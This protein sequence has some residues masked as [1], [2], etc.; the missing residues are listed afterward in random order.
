MFTSLV[1]GTVSEIS[2]GKFPNGAVTGTFVHLFNYLK[3]EAEQQVAELRAKG[4]NMT[5]VNDGT[6]KDGYYITTVDTASLK[7]TGHNA[8]YI[9][10]PKAPCIESFVCSVVKGGYDGFNAGKNIGETV[11]VYTDNINLA[12]KFFKI[13][14]IGYGMI[15]GA[16]DYYD[17]RK[18][19]Q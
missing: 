14:A 12:S 11:D 6:G 17:N 16:I 10:R 7:D 4:L 15:K 13:P 2:G 5:V 9:L 18:N 8:S 1:S 3:H 19:R